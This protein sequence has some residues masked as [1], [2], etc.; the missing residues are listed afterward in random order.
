M[1]AIGRPREFNRDA[2]LEAAMRVFWR[3]GFATASMNE[4][5]DAMGIRSP[6]L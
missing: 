6:S 2:A 1:A 3:K 5:C 4:L